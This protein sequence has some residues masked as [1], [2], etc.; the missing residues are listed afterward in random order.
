MSADCVATE[1]DLRLPS[2]ST[3][4]IIQLVEASDPV[5]SMP[6]AFRIRLRPPSQP[7]R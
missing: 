1:P 3:S 2:I 6:A 4:A 5:K 7:T